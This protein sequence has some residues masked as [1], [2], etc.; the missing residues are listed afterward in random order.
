ML[1]TPKQSPYAPPTTQ[2]NNVHETVLT[3]LGVLQA[4]SDA[5]KRMVYRIGNVAGGTQEDIVH[6]ATYAAIIQQVLMHGRYFPAEVVS[7]MLRSPGQNP[8]SVDKTS[9]QYISA[10][11]TMANASAHL[12]KQ[13][14][15]ILYKHYTTSHSSPV[16]IALQIQ[17][18]LREQEARAPAEAATSEWQKDRARHAAE[19]HKWVRDPGLESLLFKANRKPFKGF[20]SR[21]KI[22]RRYMHDLDFRVSLEA[23]EFNEASHHWVISNGRYVVGGVQSPSRSY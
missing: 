10:I 16:C 19:A 4:K 17:G 23:A 21:A 7:H 18:V 12:K 20:P 11:N 22:I 6:N 14:L 1:R 8:N 2:A 9:A 15:A 3:Q 13:F 5:E